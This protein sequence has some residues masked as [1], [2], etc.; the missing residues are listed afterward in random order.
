M[1]TH[2]NIYK[3]ALIRIINNTYFETTHAYIQVEAIY[4]F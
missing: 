4:L 2:L 1:F 3:L